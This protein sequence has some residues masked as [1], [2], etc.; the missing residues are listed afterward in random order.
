MRN[1]SRES[2]T[3]KTAIQ[4]LEELLS[5]CN[6]WFD[7]F[8]QTVK[9]GKVT[10]EGRLV[11]AVEKEKQERQK[12]ISEG[13]EPDEVPPPIETM[14]RKRQRLLSKAISTSIKLGELYA[15]EHILDMDKSHTHLLWAVEKS[16]NE[17][18]RR[19]DQGILPGE[20]NKFMSSEE[21]GGSLE[22]LGRDYERKSQFQFAIPLFFQALR[23]CEL[24]CHRA[25]IMNNLAACFAQQPLLAAGSGEISEALG[26]LFKGPLPSTRQECLEAAENWAKNAYTHAVDVKGSERTDECDQA[27]AVSLCNWGDV[28]AM[29][30]KH[31]VATKKYRQAIEMSQ[32][33]GF[34][35]GVKQAQSGLAKLKTQGAKSS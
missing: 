25:V 19:N 12:A 18:K 17:F 20:E 26:D 33:L 24:P 35:D 2:N 29:L 9:D 7:V 32:K 13:R 1:G 14:W 23:L 30:G 22:S 6:K 10:K 28:A 3:T 5:D 27:C 34:D 11:A 8:E 31:T 21:L 4:G 15:S 16:L